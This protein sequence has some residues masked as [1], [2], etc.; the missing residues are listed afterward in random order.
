MTDD[1][2]NNVV[3]VYN[4]KTGFTRK[5][6]E[7]IAIETGCQMMEL[8]DVSAKTLQGFDAVVFGSRAHTGSLEGWKKFRE[9]FAESGVRELTLFCVGAMPPDATLRIEGFWNDNLNEEELTAIPHFYLP[10][11]LC[12][13]KMSFKDKFLMFGLKMML[14][15]QK[16]KTPEV[17]GLAKAIQSSF[18]ISS[19]AYA[20]SIITYIKE[21]Y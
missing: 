12:Y 20:E 8:K 14:K 17:E 2:K 11:G 21:N 4:S 1:R 5:Y 9:T 19:P 16:E 6:A 15:K 13:E 10:G 3:I 18:D 7:I